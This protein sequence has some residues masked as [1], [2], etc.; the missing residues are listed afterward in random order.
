M[1]VRRGVFLFMF[2]CA[3]AFMGAGALLSAGA[4]IAEDITSRCTVFHKGTQM[5][6]K[7]DDKVG[8]A[9]FAVTGA[10]LELHTP[11]GVPCSHVSLRF[12]GNP[13]RVRALAPFQERWETVS[14]CEEPFAHMYLSV[15][16]L[17]HF[18]LEMSPGEGD[19]AQ[20]TGLFLYGRGEAP[21][22]VQR[23]E[24]APDKNDLLVIVAHPDD[25]L[26]YL[27]GTIPTYAGE[28]GRRVVVA[29]L[30]CANDIRRSE[31][32]NGLWHCGLRTYPD[33]AAFRDVFTRTLKDAYKFWGKKKTVGH[34]ADL[35]RKYRPDVVVTHAVSGEYGHGAHQAVSQASR[36]AVKAAADIQ[37]YPPA[38]PG[39]GPWKISKLYLHMGASDPMH[40]DWRVP[41]DAFG[42]RTA[43]DVAQ[44]A[45]LMHVSQ[46]DRHVA[47]ENRTTS[48][49]RYW[50][51]FTEV[52]KDILKND[53]FEHIPQP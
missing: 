3:S 35:Y 16:D 4:E 45:L 30:T 44:E 11:E 28:R 48:S 29:Y 49:S 24:A 27:G 34:I 23:W 18:R 46:G 41:L 5:D 51:A 31:L 40:M 47:D 7:P 26:I 36:E 25:E 8:W 12:A 10:F 19:V 32:L 2:L 50:L 21:P 39:L 17:E 52:G 53:F 20:I 14:V 22:E 43:F 37:A 6:I 33:I 42:G 1:R 13:A 15:P 9:G 38:N